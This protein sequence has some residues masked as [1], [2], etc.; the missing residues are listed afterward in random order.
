MVKANIP[1]NVNVPYRLYP[2][3]N[4]FNFLKL[5]TRTGRVWAVQYSMNDG[6]NSFEYTITNVDLAEKKQENIGRYTLYPTQNM[7]TFI[8]LDQFTGATFH[9]QWSIKRNECFIL[10]INMYGNESSR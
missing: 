10:P 3:A 6:E 5:D 7:W 8:L 9:V 2:T 1:Q 4:R